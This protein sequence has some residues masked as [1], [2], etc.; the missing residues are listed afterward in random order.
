MGFALDENK[1]VIF[2]PLLLV[3]IVKLKFLLL[4][5]RA[6]ISALTTLDIGGIIF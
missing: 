5:K 4:S 6:E 1:V 3:F 2:S